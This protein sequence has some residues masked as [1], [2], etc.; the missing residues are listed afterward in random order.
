MPRQPTYGEVAYV[1]FHKLRGIAEQ[2]IPWDDVTEESQH[3]WEN[4]AA[5]VIVVFWKK[6]LELGR[7]TSIPEQPK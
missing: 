2:M 3:L 6:Q 5:A 4:T 1:T 7:Q